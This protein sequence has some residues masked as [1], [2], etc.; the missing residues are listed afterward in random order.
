MAANGSGARAAMA[1]PRPRPPE[2]LRKSRRA[3]NGA[4]GA[5]GGGKRGKA[6]NRQADA[7]KALREGAAKLAEQVARQRG[8]GRA[9][10][11]GRNR[12]GTDPLGRP[13]R[14]YGENAG[15]DE[16]M[17][18]NEGAVERARRILEALRERANRHDRPRSELDYI[19]RL[20]KGLY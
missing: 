16:N 3:M 20:L 10:R 2:G 9:G 4:A 14:D 11:F 6:L 12:S 1:R 18:P 8:R 7:L 15:P 17:V 19:D 5:L 13:L